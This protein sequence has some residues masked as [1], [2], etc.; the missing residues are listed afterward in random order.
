MPECT[1]ACVSESRKWGSMPFFLNRQLQVEV[2]GRVT[3]F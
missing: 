1:S 2:E 3:H